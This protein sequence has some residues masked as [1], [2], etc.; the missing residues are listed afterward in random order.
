MEFM[1]IQLQPGKRTRRDAIERWI[2]KNIVPMILEERKL[3]YPTMPN[4]HADPDAPEYIIKIDRRKDK[5]GEKYY[6]IKI[7]AD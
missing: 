6:E 2:E 3:S 1:L 5:D 4:P 7:F